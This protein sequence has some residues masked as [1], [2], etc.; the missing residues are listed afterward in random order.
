MQDTPVHVRQRNLLQI[1]V[2]HMWERDSAY[3]ALIELLRLNFGDR[4]ADL[5]VP[6]SEALQLMSVGRNAMEEE[7]TLQ[8]SHLRLSAGDRGILF[9]QI[10]EVSNEMDAAHERVRAQERGARL[11]RLLREAEERI[12]LGKMSGLGSR[13]LESELNWLAS[14]RSRVTDSKYE[15][16]IHVKLVETYVGLETRLR[17]LKQQ[18][19][20]IED[21]IRS[22]RE[23]LT[24]LEGMLDPDQ[25]NRHQHVNPLMRA[26]RGRTSVARKCPTLALAIYER[27]RRADLVFVLASANDL[28]REWMEFEAELV[29]GMHKVVILIRPYDGAP[30]P[31]EFE[32]YAR[33]R[34]LNLDGNDLIPMI[35]RSVTG[36]LD[37][38]AL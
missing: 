1:F 38:S 5:S 14:L 37:E 12:A 30:A 26:I 34:S 7:S 32:W 25:Y 18:L 2:S 8:E 24:E 10:F 19:A 22:R 9:R 15:A 33:S 13:R 21:E 3:L 6:S 36:F 31:P 35:L 23:R 27:I 11:Q 17:A 20:V 29:T 4:V 16:G 28:Y